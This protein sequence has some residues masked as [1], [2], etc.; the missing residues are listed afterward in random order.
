[1]KS[2]LIATFMAAAGLALSPQASKAEFPEQPV[3]MIVGFSAGGGTDTVARLIATELSE[4]WGQTVVVENQ[5]GADGSIAAATVANAEPDGYTVAVVSNAHTISPSTRELPYEPVESFEPITLI[6]SQPNLL[7]LHPS[8][9]ANTLQ[10]LI[11]LAKSKPGELT[12]GSSGAGTSPYL[13]MERLKQMAG[14]DMVHVPYKG[15][16]PAVLGIVSGEVDLMFGAVST[17][18]PHVKEGALK[19]IAVS[20]K[21]RIPNAPDVPTVDES[22]LAGFQAASWYG[23]LAPAGTPKDVVAKLNADIVAVLKSEEMSARLAEMGFDLV[24]NSP[25]E[26]TEVLREDITTWGQVIANIKD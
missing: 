6:A 13:A 16:A 19:A 22:G 26:F 9:E 17:T 1:M 11:E 8:I 4:V 12:F 3:T 18:L 21:E 23:I 7:L 24:A 20:T 10:E 5:P 25:E 15:S 14:L 2:A